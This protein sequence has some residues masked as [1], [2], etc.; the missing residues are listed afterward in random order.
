MDRRLVGDVAARRFTTSAPSVNP[1]GDMLALPFDPGSPPAVPADTDRDGMA[2]AWERAAGLD[3]ADAA[4]RNDTGLSEARL[5]VSGY[6]NLE[7]Y[8]AELAARR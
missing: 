5:G 1:A 7:V 2:D 6:T 8:L 3:P 4:D